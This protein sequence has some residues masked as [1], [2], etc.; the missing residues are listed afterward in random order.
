MTFKPVSLP[1]LLKSRL[2]ERRVVP[3]VGAG[4]STAAGLPDWPGL[5][6]ALVTWAVHSGVP[7][8]RADLIEEAIQKNNFDRASHALSE[9]LG[10]R[11]PEALRSILSPPGALP[12][13][14]HRILAKVV[15]PVVITTNFDKLLPE[16]FEGRPALVWDEQEAIGDALR[17]GTPHLMLAHG[18]IQNPGSTVLTPAEYRDS[19][20]NPALQNYLR[21][22]L[23][24]YSLLFLGYSLGDWDLKFFL[25]ELRFAFGPQRSRTSPCLPVI[26]SMN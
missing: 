3:F 7:V 8:P 10:V 18:W 14:V 13:P 15:W 16:A 20:R 17:T 24:Q 23:S 19:F 12:T 5:L 1:A 11:L 4:I 22:I 26:G 25:E 6:R 2:N 21:T 9:A